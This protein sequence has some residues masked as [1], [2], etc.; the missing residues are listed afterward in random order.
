MIRTSEIQV[1]EMLYNEGKSAV[2]MCALHQNNSRCGVEGDN[3]LFMC[4]CWRLAGVGES[5]ERRQI[6]KEKL[7]TCLQ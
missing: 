6:A 3:Y 1:H 4:V 5:H 2:D 7:F